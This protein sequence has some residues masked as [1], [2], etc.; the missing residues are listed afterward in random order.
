MCPANFESG[1]PERGIWS[2]PGFGSNSAGTTG[3]AELFE[4][5]VSQFDHKIYQYIF[6]SITHISYACCFNIHYKTSNCTKRKN[7][8]HGK[9]LQ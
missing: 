2:L 1:R 8:I 9:S 3:R 5:Q 4:R 7:F 6:C